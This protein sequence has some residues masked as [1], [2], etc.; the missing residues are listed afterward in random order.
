MDKNTE[1]EMD[2]GFRGIRAL[3]KNPNT[4]LGVPRI[5]T[6]VFWGLYWVLIGGDSAWCPWGSWQL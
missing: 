2:T 5:T 3:P 6:I 1:N 4:I